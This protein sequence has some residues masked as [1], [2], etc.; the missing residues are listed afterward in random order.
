MKSVS[1]GS[2]TEVPVI[3]PGL[4]LTGSDR[5][6]RYAAELIHLAQARVRPLDSVHLAVNLSA[7]RL[8]H[9]FT[10]QLGLPPS[11]YLKLCRLESARELFETTFLSVKEVAATVGAGDVSHF[12]RDFKARFGNSP[13]AYRRSLGRA[14]ASEQCAATTANE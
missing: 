10:Q 12:V 2:A 1:T 5:R 4:P 8:R 7:S 14:C 13:T 3:V 11:E 9:L 6:I